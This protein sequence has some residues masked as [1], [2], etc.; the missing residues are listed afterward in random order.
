[1]E[2]E[3]WKSIKVPSTE[4]VVEM[5]WKAYKAL[6]AQ[7][8]EQAKKW[9]EDQKVRGR[10]RDAQV[11]KKSRAMGKGKEKEKENDLEGSDAERD[12][13]NDIDKGAEG[14]AGAGEIAP[15]YSLGPDGLRESIRFT[16]HH[17]S[18]PLCFRLNVEGVGQSGSQ[19]VSRY[20]SRRGIS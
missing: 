17:I 13:G 1:M 6:Q 10:G 15:C 7:Q 8:A 16:D 11:R 3:E 20:K 2:E 12:E 14:G 18:Q 5:A 19:G 9:E 4:T